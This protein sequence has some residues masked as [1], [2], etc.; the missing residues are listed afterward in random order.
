L[1]IDEWLKLYFATTNCKF[2]LSKRKSKFK[3]PKP[4]PV[5]SGTL[6][7]TALEHAGD[8][9][10]ENYKILKELEKDD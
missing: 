4:T 1:T 3:F 8:S 6:T 10:K 7:K 9:I 2:D 5:Y